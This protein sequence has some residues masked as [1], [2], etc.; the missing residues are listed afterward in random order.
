MSS[1]LDVLT[2][3]KVF[4]AAQGATKSGTLCA[5]HVHRHHN[6]NVNLLEREKMLI[7]CTE[8]NTWLMA[9]SGEQSVAQMWAGRA[10]T[11]PLLSGEEAQTHAEIG[12]GLAGQ[13]V[14]FLHLLQDGR[15]KPWGRQ[16][17]THSTQ[18]CF[19]Y[20]ERRQSKFSLT[21]CKRQAQQPSDD[22]NSWCR[23]LIKRSC[24]ILHIKMMLVISL[25]RLVC[26]P[27]W[28]WF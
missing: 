21:G 10:D 17:Q 25:I 20:G 23:L 12:T 27:T 26:I 4:L 16:T 11:H 3:W 13:I 18:S 19:K 2:G 22:R 24:S 7:D 14:D 6:L 1:F 5:N 8:A 15:R 9:A 28:W